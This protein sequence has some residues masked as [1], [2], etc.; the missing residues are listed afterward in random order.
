M[1]LYK[2][3]GQVFLKDIKYIKKI[4]D[5]NGTIEEEDVLEIGSGSG[6]LTKHLINK[7]K[8]IYCVEVDNRLCEL[9]KDKFNQFSNIEIINND[10]LKFPLG[11]LGKKVIVFGNI[12]YQISNEIIQY[13]VTNRMYIKKAYLTLQKEFSQKLTAPVS[14]KAYKY[15]SC[16]IQYYARVK[17][18]FDIPAKAF[19]PVP[20]VN[21][22]FV[23]I[24]FYTELPHRAQNEDFLFEI[25]RAAFSCRRK[26]I[27]NALPDVYHNKKEIFSSLN[28]S[29]SLRPCDISLKEYVL[30]ADKFSKDEDNGFKNI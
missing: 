8:F 26:K 14:S 17:K 27:I 12:P 3:F 4:S 7:A 2:H 13:L 5:S 11:K 1:R 9:L 18:I 21:S 23:E 25:I 28:I 15:L 29:F 19:S 6:R 16:Y 22:S 30:L 24:D 10:I 20:K